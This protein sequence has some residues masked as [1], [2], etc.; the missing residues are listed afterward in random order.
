MRLNFLFVLVS[1]LIHSSTLLGNDN[2]KDLKWSALEGWELLP[3]RAMVL[4]SYQRKTDSGPVKMSITVF[5]GDVGGDLAN[6]N[7]WLRQSGMDAVTEDTLPTVLKQETIAGR[8]W[9]KVNLTSKESGML[10]AYTMSAGKSWFFKITGPSAGIQS[11]E[12][13]FNSFLATVT[14][15]K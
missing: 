11:I 2:T 15:Q 4:E 5:P 13:S 9:K 7:R 3:A 14:S 6:V 1:L 12:E 10:V 8:E